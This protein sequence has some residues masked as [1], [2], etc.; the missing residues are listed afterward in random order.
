M[1]QWW[2]FDESLMSLWWVYEQQRSNLSGI[3]GYCASTQEHIMAST[4]L[5]RGSA[6]LEWTWDLEQWMAVA[7]GGGGGYWASLR[8]NY[9][10][11][12]Q[13]Q[14]SFPNVAL[15][16][17]CFCLA[18]DS[19]DSYAYGPYGRNVTVMLLTKSAVP[20]LWFFTDEKIGRSLTGNFATDFNLDKLHNFGQRPKDARSIALDILVL[21]DL[22]VLSSNLRLVWDLFLLQNNILPSLRSFQSQSVQASIREGCAR[23]AGYDPPWSPVQLRDTATAQVFA[24][25]LTRNWI[26]WMKIIILAKHQNIYISKVFLK[27]K[28]LAER[29]CWYSTRCTEC[30]HNA[31]TMHHQMHHQMHFLKITPT[32]GWFSCFLPPTGHAHTI[33]KLLAARFTWHRERLCGFN[34]WR[35]TRVAIN[36]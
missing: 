34:H 8:N 7:C 27:F 18:Q 15:C 1:I 10:R 35:V 29:N 30:I 12:C 4:C 5:A 31:Y 21:S 32:H 19:Y 17:P 20:Q 9:G 26:N 14:V 2:V 24:T 28:R 16:E 6:E 33:S 3:V 13:F 25:R 36:W 22:S 23:Y 11:P